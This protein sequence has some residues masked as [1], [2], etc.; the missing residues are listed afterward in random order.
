MDGGS[1]QC[2]IESRLF[3]FLFAQESSTAPTERRRGRRKK[4]SRGEGTVSS[5]RG[6]EA[7]AVVMTQNVTTTTA[8]SSSSFLSLVAMGV[9]LYSL[10]L[11]TCV[12]NAMVLYAIRTEKR[13]Q[14]VSDLKLAV[15]LS[16]G[17]AVFHDHRCSRG[18]EHGNSYVLVRVRHTRGSPG[19]TLLARVHQECFCSLV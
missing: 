14:T 5:S 6:L 10:S 2:V 16:R 11:V 9:G 12:G 13:L 3:F 19:T 8:T 4:L 1:N 15:D 17:G 18:N 7:G